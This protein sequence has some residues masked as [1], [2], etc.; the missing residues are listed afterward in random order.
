V[1][2]G[3]R[4]ARSAKAEDVAMT[5]LRAGTALALSGG[6]FRATLFHAGALVRLNECALLGTLARISSVSGGSIAA[7]RLA[8]AWRRLDF[9]AGVATNLGPEVVEPLRAFCAR[10]VDRRAV[11]LGS[12]S[13]RRTVGDAL[14]R[15]YAEELLEDAE[16]QS[17]PDAPRFV[18]NATNL[19]SGR[20]VRI[21]KPYM[22]DWRVGRVDA[23]AIPLARAV[24]ASSAFPPILSPVT[25]DATGMAWQRQPGADLFEDPGQRGVLQL[26]D[27]GAYD[28]LGLETIDDFATLLVSDAGAPFS[29]EGEDGVAWLGQPMRALDIATDQARALR[30]RMLLER[31]PV[32]GQKVAYWGIDTRIADYGL[33]DAMPVRTEVADPLA[34]LRTRLN[35]F[36]E[37]EQGRLIN[38]GYALADAAI[39]R[40]VPGTN[41]PAPSWPVPGFAL[42]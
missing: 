36:D 19:R 13:L 12:L 35:P 22:A 17:L 14:E 18:F 3:T 16:L 4:R 30:K 6:G 34:R 9:V 5:E 27:G 40:F 28:N 15:I 42:R 39:R 29:V 31:A 33:P 1:T 7:G 2:Q 41:G 8:V 37:A 25:I 23:P 32:R 38:W 11:A 26:T 10:D 21:A 24:A 20:L